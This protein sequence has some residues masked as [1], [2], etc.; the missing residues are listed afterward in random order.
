[1]TKLSRSTK[2][3]WIFTPLMERLSGIIDSEERTG[4]GAAEVM[5]SL[6][7]ISRLLR[8]LVITP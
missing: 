8:G 2:R 3:R 1:M 7:L 6:P 4:C 5:S